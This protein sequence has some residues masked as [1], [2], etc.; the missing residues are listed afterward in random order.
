M[1][2]TT[3]TKSE[4]ILIDQSQSNGKSCSS[5]SASTSSNNNGS[6]LKTFS[7]SRLAKKSRH[8]HHHHSHHNHHHHQNRHNEESASTSTSIDQS[9][10]STIIN[11]ANDI[12]IYRNLLPII[13]HIQLL[14]ELVL[15]NE[16]IAVITQTPNVCSEIVSALIA[17]IA[18]LRYGADYRPF[19]TIHDSEFKEY[20]THTK[21]P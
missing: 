14:W 18:P 16:P 8:H 15:T 10:S 13:T 9:S 19:F 1:C 6:L 5:S 20:T 3:A 2:Q 7:L 17:L 12:N 21:S 4:S 11:V